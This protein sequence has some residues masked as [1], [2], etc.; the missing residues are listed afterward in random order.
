MHLNG[1]NTF[2][3]N[4]ATIIPTAIMSLCLCIHFNDALKDGEGLL[5]LRGCLPKYWFNSGGSARGHCNELMNKNTAVVWNAVKCDQQMAP[6]HKHKDTNA[7]EYTHM[8]KLSIMKCQF[9][10]QGFEL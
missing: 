5:S 9:I 10:L 4:P 2:T 6:T 8:H 7:H 1:I 3:E